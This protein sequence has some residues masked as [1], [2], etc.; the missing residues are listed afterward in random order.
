MVL[1]ENEI[2]IFKFFI[3]KQEQTQRGVSFHILFTYL[4][5]PSHAFRIPAIENIT[6]F[7]LLIFL[8]T[9]HT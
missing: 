7:V 2:M 9:K 4:V 3:Y 6:F 5:F 1:Y 8:R